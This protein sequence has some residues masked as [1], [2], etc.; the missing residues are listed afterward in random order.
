MLINQ[1]S[2]ETIGIDLI[3]ASKIQLNRE[4][5]SNHQDVFLTRFH[6]WYKN[7]MVNEVPSSLAVN[8][9][10]YSLLIS[11]EFDKVFKTGFYQQAIVW[12]NNGLSISCVTM[13]FS[14]FRLLLV[15]AAEEI[16]DFSLA[17]ALS[18]KVDLA[19]NIALDVYSLHQA[20]NNLK[21]QSQEKVARIRHT[22]RLISDEM[23]EELIQAYVDHQNWKLRAYRCAL[24]EID[25]GNF[26]FST[27][28]CRLGKWLNAGGIK[29]IADEELPLFLAAHEQVHKLGFLALKNAKEQM[30]ELVVNYIE[31]MEI[32]SDEVCRVLLKCI[33][34]EFSRLAHLD[35]LTRLTNRKGFDIALQHQF[36]LAKRYDLW[37]GL[38]LVDVDHFK[39]VNDQY[40]HSLGDKF[41]AEL[42]EIL[43]TT[44]RMEDQ[45][46]RWGG[47]EFAVIALDKTQQGCALLSERIRSAVEQNRFSLEDDI[48]IQAT[49]SVGALSFKPN[50]KLNQSSIFKNADKALYQAKRNGRNQVIAKTLE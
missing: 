50:E 7:A 22:F 20:L 12:Q 13:L 6:D 21:T 33:D 31:D 46:Y 29:K 34:I 14:E 19:L 17:S 2:T 49:V 48:T 44:I 3:Q 38:I 28:E 47:E 30:P 37:M 24:G 1:P 15:Q 9:T 25:S 16:N 41:L 18:Q 45:V 8:E 43:Q 11:A 42:A 39:K 5:L 32:A 35:A 40:G 27:D 10:V 23:P 4:F 26:P 36:S